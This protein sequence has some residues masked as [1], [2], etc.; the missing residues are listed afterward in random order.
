ME[1]LRDGL[2]QFVGAVLA[3]VAIA[4]SF[5]IYYA[6]R[7]RRE[8]AFGVLSKRELLP[9]VS[10]LPRSIQIIVDG[11]PAI[12]VHLF[13]LALKNT[14]N[15]PIR[16]TDFRYPPSI[17]FGNNSKILHVSLSRQFPTNLGITLT[18]DAKEARIEPALLN[19]GEHFVLQALVTGDDFDVSCD[20]RAEGITELVGVEGAKYNVA[21][22]L[23]FMF[24]SAIAIVLLVFT[25]GII[26]V[27]YGLVKLVQSK[28]VPFAIANAIVSL[29][30]GVLFFGVPF[31]L[32]IRARQAIRKRRNRYVPEA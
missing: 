25:S 5:W 13:V 17:K 6:Q 23:T 9:E 1:L 2:W 22:N 24:V 29:P 30:T 28:G 15:T 32:L 27:G 16:Q 21:L 14:G 20:F 18:H 4:G 11:T 3:L 31:A 8:V 26:D 10:A 12:N 7:S 19:P